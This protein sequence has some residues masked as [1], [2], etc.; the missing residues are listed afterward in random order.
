MSKMHLDIV[1]PER[2]VY[3]KEV[4][5]VITRA[6]N[7]DIGILPHHAPLVSPLSVTV[8]R[9]KDE[10]K[11]ERIAISGGFLE[12]RPS[13]VTILAETAELS[14]DIDVAR[15]EAAASRAKGRISEHDGDLARAELALRRAVNRLDVAKWK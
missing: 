4:E 9:V 12:V 7:G 8:L 1:T 15:A 5:M 10:G 13:G 6:A 14:S 3:S 11:E 2:K